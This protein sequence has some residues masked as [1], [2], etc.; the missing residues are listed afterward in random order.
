MTKPNARTIAA[1]L[2][3]LLVAAVA[4]FGAIFMIARNADKPEPTVT[5]YAH[6]KS[7][8]VQPYLYCGVRMDDCRVLPQED[9][10]LPAQLTC[11]EGE[12]CHTGQSNDLEVPAGYPLQLSLPK[13]VID[14]PWLI[15]ALYRTPDGQILENQL[16]HRDFDEGTAA[17]TI[18]SVPKLPLLGVEIQLSI[19]TR[20]MTTGQEGYMPHAAWSV[21]TQV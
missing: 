1:L 5:A 15:V 6:G 11:P 19:L 3:V 2:A 8:T 16:T 17:V 20:D 9:I 7:I 10:G 18:P 13:E 4:Y 12:D 14:S 21:R